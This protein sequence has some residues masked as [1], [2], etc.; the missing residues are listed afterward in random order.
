MKAA[1]QTMSLFGHSLAFGASI[2]PENLPGWLVKSKTL[3]YSGVTFVP[4][5]IA[6]QKVLTP[7]VLTEQFLAAGMRGQA[8]LFITPDMGDTQNPDD[9]SRIIE[10]LKPQLKYGI[11]LHEA[12][13]GL[14]MVVGPAHTTWCKQYPKKGVGSW[15]K[16]VFQTWLQHLNALARKYNFRIAL[17]ALNDTEDGTQMPSTKSTRL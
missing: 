7:A 2:T 3:G 12:G 6:D 4:A 11:A 13:L 5:T 10:A 9:H 8:C 15:N 17:E 16:N 1:D 14:P